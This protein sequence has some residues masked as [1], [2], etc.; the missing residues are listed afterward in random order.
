MLFLGVT[1]YLHPQDLSVAAARALAF[2]PIAHAPIYHAQSF[3]SDSR[4]LADDRR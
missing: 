2:S 1:S 3:D 4:R